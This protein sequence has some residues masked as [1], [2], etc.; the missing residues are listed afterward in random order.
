MPSGSGATHLVDVATLTGAV[1]RALGNQV[2]GAFGTPQSFYDEV[3][4]AGERAGERYWQLPLIEDYVAEMESWY[5]DL[6]NSGS[7]EGGLDQER[8]LPARV[9]DPA[10]GP[11]RHRLDRL[12]P[13]GHAYAPRGATGASH[14]TLVELAL[15]GARAG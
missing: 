4:A 7:P 5:G 12:L 9:R 15:A 1:G 2:T 8:A 14:A 3:V 11:S 10:V 13:Q 6:T